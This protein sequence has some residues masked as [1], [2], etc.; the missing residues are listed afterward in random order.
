M[1]WPLAILCAFVAL[2]L[3]AAWAIGR[4]LESDPETCALRDAEGK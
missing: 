2:Y 4:F 1:T 3:A